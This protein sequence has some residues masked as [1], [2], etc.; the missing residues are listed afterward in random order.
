[1]IPI[2][3]FPYTD[4][5]DLNL[6][7]LLRQIQIFEADLEELKRRVK[8]LE[9]WRIDVVEPDL[10]TIKADIRDIKGDIIS[11]G[12]RITTVE[13]DIVT[14]NNTIDVIAG[15]SKTF[16]IKL[17]S[18]DTVASVKEGDPNTGTVIDLTDNDAFDAFFNRSQSSLS[19]KGEINDR[20]FVSPYDDNAYYEGKLYRSN[21]GIGIIIE[22]N[23]TQHCTILRYSAGFRQSTHSTNV[24][25]SMIGYRH[26]VQDYKLTSNSWES[27][28]DATYPYKKR[29]SMAYL[30]EGSQVDIY[31]RTLSDFETYSADFS[32][33]ID[34]ETGWI[35]IYSKTP[36]AN[37]VWIK[38]I[39]TGGY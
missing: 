5:H 11:L 15:N 27:S 16:Y 4:Y 23:D 8:A 1:M 21:T 18:D 19:S 30:N 13:G 3:N 26:I 37:D 10:I 7:F 14:I 28:G 25:I 29:I 20:Y 39:I 22:V 36:L 33:Y 6:D 17:A 34:V 24:L 9:D 2:R 38:I 35:T 31:F 12:D 32:E